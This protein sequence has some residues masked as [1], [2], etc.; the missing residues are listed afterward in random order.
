VSSERDKKDLEWLRVKIANRKASSRAMGV[1][2]S[3]EHAER[4]AER[5]ES[6]EEFIR[7]MHEE[8]NEIEASLAEG[9]GY[10]HDKDYGWVVGD[11]TPLT[12]AD[13]AKTRLKDLEF[14]RGIA[15]DVLA[16]LQSHVPVPW[17]MRRA[18]A[19]ALAFRHDKQSTNEEDG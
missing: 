18:F 10:S 14:M 2:L 8:F 16:H 4:L 17:F 1:Q 7:G 11:H 13:E 15:G 12:L 6:H 9:L 5:I 3:V 19:D